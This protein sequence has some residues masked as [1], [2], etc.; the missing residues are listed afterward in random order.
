MDYI[1]VT[2]AADKIKRTRSWIHQLLQA[3]R[4]PGARAVGKRSSRDG[5]GAKVYVYSEDEPS[6]LVGFRQIQ[7][8]SGYGR[9]SP[10]EAH[11]GLGKKPAA[12]YRVEVLFP[13][14]KKRVVTGVK[15]GRILSVKEGD[16]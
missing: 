16:L 4:I 14:G 1:T 5:L 15:P 7:S 8:G 13:R 6:K 10:L 11:F 9:C 3:R 2:E 12:S